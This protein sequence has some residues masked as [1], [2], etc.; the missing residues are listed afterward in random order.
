MFIIKEQL[1]IHLLNHNQQEIDSCQ[2]SETH[3]TLDDVVIEILE[4]HKKDKK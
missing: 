3:S 4:A 1:F 2:Q